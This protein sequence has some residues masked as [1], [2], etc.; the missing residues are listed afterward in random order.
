VAIE[1]DTTLIAQ[2][3]SWIVLSHLA[4]VPLVGLTGDD[5]APPVRVDGVCCSTSASAR[6]CFDVSMK[7]PLKTFRCTS[8]T[9]LPCRV[10]TLAFLSRS[11][12]RSW[13]S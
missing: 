3:E 6:S 7:A 4:R 9:A 12:S 10:R 2:T 5:A 13:T 1:D 11:A 8:A